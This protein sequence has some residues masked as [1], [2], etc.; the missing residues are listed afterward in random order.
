MGVWDIRPAI[1]DQY[2]TKR[3][4]G[5]HKTHPEICCRGYRDSVWIDANVD[6]RTLYVADQICRRNLNILIPIHNHRDCIYDE[7][8]VVQ[9]LK[10]DSDQRCDGMRCVLTAAGMPRHYGLNET[11]ITYRRYHHKMVRAIDQMW[12]DY[13]VTYSW[14]DQLSLSYI[15]WIYGIRPGDIAIN[16]TR[17]DKDNFVVNS[18]VDS[19]SRFVF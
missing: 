17:E 4:S 15:L 7:V 1:C 16:N 2:D 18:H 19:Q 12:W 8:D 9:K 6:L 14:R 11:N 3:N 5:W 10:L 13:N